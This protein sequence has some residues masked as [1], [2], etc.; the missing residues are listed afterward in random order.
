MFHFK[1]FHNEAIS[2]TAYL[3][4]LPIHEQVEGLWLNYYKGCLNSARDVQAA[5]SGYFTFSWHCAAERIPLDL[6]NYTKK[7]MFLKL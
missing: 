6:Q 4:L 7:K 5:L 2:R 3:N 1:I